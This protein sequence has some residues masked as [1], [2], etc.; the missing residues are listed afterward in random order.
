MKTCVAIAATALIL[1]ATFDSAS[2]LAKYLD[3]LPN[4]SSFTQELGHPGADSSKLTDFATAFAAAGHSWTTDFCGETF[5]GS[6]MTNGEAFGD[7]CC[8]WTK[9][10]TPDFTVTAFTTTPG[11]AT[12]CASTVASTT[13]STAASTAGSSTSSTPSATTVT[14]SPTTDAPTPST[15]TASPVIPAPVY[16]D[17]PTTTPSTTA[18]QTQ[19]PSS[20]G[21]AV[22]SDGDSKHGKGGNSYRRFRH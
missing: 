16:T 12:V 9:G 18:P 21:C 17:A 4:G 10:G 13:S 15:T 5:P 11:K 2:G 3:E 8:T 14:A 20:G 22:K 19:S 7:P 6:S 1:A